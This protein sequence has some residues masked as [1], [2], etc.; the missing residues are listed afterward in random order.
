MLRQ[1]QK[2]ERATAAQKQQTNSSS[3]KPSANNGQSRPTQA[4]NTETETEIEG[5]NDTGADDAVATPDDF[6]GIPHVRGFTS[7][8][9]MFADGVPEHLQCPKQWVG[10]YS[11]EID[12]L[13]EIHAHMIPILYEIL[14]KYNP[15]RPLTEVWP[16]YIEAERF[17]YAHADPE[18]ADINGASGRFDWSYQHMLDFPEIIILNEEDSKRNGFLRQVLIGHWD[19][20]WNQHK[21]P[22]G[23]IFYARHDTNYDV[24][25]EKHSLSG[26]RFGHAG[27]DAPRI[28]IY[29]HSITDEELKDI[30]G[31]NYNI[32]PYS[33]GLYTLPPNATKRYIEK[34]Y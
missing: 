24:I 3:G 31:W 13:S 26:Y 11:H 30:S 9:P 2:T 1:Q 14:T 4:S 5:E 34:Y 29:A 33:T 28:T 32:D 6:A 20:D 12:D 18:H 19:A 27:S 25:T 17:Y 8:N 7:T 22:D 23:R 15:E 16:A 21:L 10:L